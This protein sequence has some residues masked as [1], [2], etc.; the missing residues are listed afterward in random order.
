MEQGAKRLNIWMKP[1]DLE[2]LD[3]L[4]KETGMCHAAN[5]R[6]ALKMMDDIIQRKATVIMDDIPVHWIY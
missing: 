2:R 4:K 1:D 6:I 3:R 5:V